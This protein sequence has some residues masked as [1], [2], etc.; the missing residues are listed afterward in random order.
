MNP[1]QPC[2]PTHGI[3]SV[4]S[5]VIGSLLGQARPTDAFCL[6][7]GSP[8]EF[9]YNIETHRFDFSL[10]NDDAALLNAINRASIDFTPDGSKETF[11]L[12]ISNRQDLF[13]GTVR[14]AVRSQSI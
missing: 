4:N 1:L 7:G 2:E 12:D 11:S 6:A 5:T 8:L 14:D 13:A 9:V 3:K 10:I